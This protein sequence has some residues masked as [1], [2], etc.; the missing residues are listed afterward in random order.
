MDEPGITVIA[1]ATSPSGQ[2]ITR[3]FA[4]DGSLL[5]ALFSRD[6]EKLSPLNQTISMSSEHLLTAALDL[7]QTEAASQVAAIVQARLGR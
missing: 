2:A 6:A 1:G 3:R 7:R 4:R 5:A